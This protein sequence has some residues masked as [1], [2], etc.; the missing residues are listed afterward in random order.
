MARQQACTVRARAHV[1][2]Q[3]PAR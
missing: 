3:A 2:G 1:A